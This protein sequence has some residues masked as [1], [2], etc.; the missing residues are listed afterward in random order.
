MAI[1][2]EADLS[3]FIGR[4]PRRLEKTPDPEPAQPAT[5]LRSC[6]A[7][8]KALIPRPSQRGLE[9]V[10]KASTIDRHT[11]RATVP[12]FG[13]EIA[14]SEADRVTTDPLCCEVDQPLDHIV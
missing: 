11:Q 10:G 3:A 1:R 4:A 13:D 14:P 2:V 12:K 5:G 9:V 6:L 7:C 8:R